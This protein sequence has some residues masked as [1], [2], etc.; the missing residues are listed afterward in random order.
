V[1]VTTEFQGNLPEVHLD[2][3]QLQQVRLNLVKNAIEATSAS[4]PILNIPE[5]TPISRRKP[6]RTRQFV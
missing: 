5:P 1:S 3:T 2:D 4:A 6:N